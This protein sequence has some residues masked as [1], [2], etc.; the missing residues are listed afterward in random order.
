[1]TYS[2]GYVEVVPDGIDGL[3]DCIEF[4]LYGVCRVFVY[5]QEFVRV[6]D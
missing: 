3:Y 5:F 4:L 2:L 6:T 1:M